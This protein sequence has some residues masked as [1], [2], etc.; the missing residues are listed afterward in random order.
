MRKLTTGNGNP[1]P[2]KPP[3][4]DPMRQTPP[5]EPLNP[6]ADEEAD[7]EQTSTKK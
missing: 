1:P 3:V 4:Q 6:S 7:Q 5:A 2:K